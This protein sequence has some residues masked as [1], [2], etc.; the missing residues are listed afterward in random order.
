M[1]LNFNLL[2]NAMWVGI[3]EAICLLSIYKSDSLPSEG[4]LPAEADVLV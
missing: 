1:P 4:G 2:G 3:S